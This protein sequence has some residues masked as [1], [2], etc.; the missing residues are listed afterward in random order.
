[1]NDPGQLGDQGMRPG[2]LQRVRPTQQH[3]AWTLAR[4][5]CRD[6]PLLLGCG[7]AHIVQRG[8][9]MVAQRVPVSLADK[10]DVTDTQLDRRRNYRRDNPRRPLQND[11]EPRPLIT[12]E[13]Q[14][15]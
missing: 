12:T 13:S 6:R 2:R 3:G 8:V 5:R 7:R 15:P 11:M 9:R 14:T 1:M 10:Y 4:Y